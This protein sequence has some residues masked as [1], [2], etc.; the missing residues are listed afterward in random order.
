MR[1]RVSFTHPGESD[2]WA[3]QYPYVQPWSTFPGFSQNTS[4][5]PVLHWIR[6]RNGDVE[7]LVYRWSHSLWQRTASG[8]SAEDRLGS[9]RFCGETSMTLCTS[10]NS[11]QRIMS[12]PARPERARSGMKTGQRC[13]PYNEGG[14]NCQ[15]WTE[16]VG[17]I[18]LD[19]RERWT[20]N[21]SDTVRVV[22]STMVSSPGR[23]FA[24]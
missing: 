13:S 8:R 6:T 7:A 23:R 11:S 10:K 5:L 1:C 16:N 14:K 22:F 20:G 17:V 15:S 21:S 24:E 3:N 19:L 4:P 9:H 18:F 2:L 12:T